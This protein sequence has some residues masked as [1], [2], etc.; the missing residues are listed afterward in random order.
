M[1]VLYFLGHIIRQDSPEATMRKQFTLLNTVGMDYLDIGAKFEL[2]GLLPACAKC[3][4]LKEC[5]NPQYNAPGVTRF[6]CFQWEI[7]NNARQ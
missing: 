4:R 5:G 1:V 7:G 3:P 6:E 2:Y